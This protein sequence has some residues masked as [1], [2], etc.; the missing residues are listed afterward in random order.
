MSTRPVGVSGENSRTVYVDI[1]I[2]HSVLY[3]R[4]NI[5]L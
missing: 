5:I 1:L 3:T 4:Q 2:E